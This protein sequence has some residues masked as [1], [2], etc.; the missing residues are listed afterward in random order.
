MV[1]KAKAKVK[2]Q[3]LK[4]KTNKKASV[5]KKSENNKN[6]KSQV[7]R[8]KPQKVDAKIWAKEFDVKI[9]E[10]DFDAALT[11][12]NEVRG[13]KRWQRLNL[14]SSVA[15]HQD[16]MKECEDYMRQSVRESDCSSGVKRNLSA[17]LVSQGRMAE[18]LPFAQTA[19]KESPKDL[20]AL[21]LYL[22]C[23][24][25]L[26]QGE[27]VLKVCKDPK[28]QFPHD[29]SVMIAYASALRSTSKPEDA[30]KEIDRL[31]DI[32]PEEPVVHRLKAD[33]LGDIDSH[34]AIK[35]YDSALKLSEKIQGEKDPAVQWNMSLHLLR[36]R[37]FERGWPAWEQGFH[38]VVGTMG[39]NLPARI[40][41]LPR[42]E[43]VK[44][45]DKN[46]WTLVCAEQGIGDQ[47][48]FLTVMED[49]IKD[50]GKVL[51]VC[52]PRMHP[53]MER[54]YENLELA[55][56]GIT[57]DWHRT[58]LPKNGYIPL[59]SLPGKYIKSTE[60]F[61][62]YRKPFL[63]ANGA[64]Y[65][66]YREYFKK[67]ANGKP[68]IGISWKG[69]YWAIQRKTKA[70]LLENWKAIFE[71]DALFVNLQYG[72]IKEDLEY[73]R[74]NK[75]NL[76]NFPKVNYKTDLDDW[77]AIT[78][79]CDG[80]ISISTALVH[81]AGAIGQKVALIMPEKQGPWIL[82]L[83]DTQSIAYKNVRIFRREKGE[84]LS[85]LIKRVASLIIT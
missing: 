30:E 36:T 28:N 40:K 19:W 67:Q 3:I 46:K 76:I 64:L 48:L 25:D 4:R 52:E 63:K 71:K 38:K 20:K 29:K 59:G 66:K 2:N 78:A 16:K 15:A 39:R 70:L 62:K 24:L 10:K 31:L 51:Y 21:Q 61:I 84:E 72:D 35:Y 27:H 9:K 32:F 49:F 79:A 60:D 18:A 23:L 14:L 83:S 8:M 53:I 44:K 22:N 68:V 65:K 69:G 56:P 54:S 45:I 42:I 12:V 43:K 85:D 81:F 33:L 37:D 50:H 77:V 58:S 47:V 26:G 11:M 17:L 55:C 57:F 74:K 75:L 41:S 6:T 80:I 73:L 5:H 7:R 34:R 1:T 82:G 13:I